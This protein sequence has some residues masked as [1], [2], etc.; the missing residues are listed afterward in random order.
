[1]RARVGALIGT[2][3]IGARPL[4]HVGLAI[5]GAIGV[6]LSAESD[7]PVDDLVVHLAGC[8]RVLIQVKR[9]VGL[10]QRAGQAV[11]RAVEQFARSVI[12]GLGPEDWLVLA[13]V[14]PVHALVQL[15]RLLD[16]ERLPYHGSPSGGE[17]RAREAFSRIARRYLDARGVKRLLARLVIWHT[18]PTQADGAAALEAHLETSVC[19]RGH[20][21]DAARELSDI[22]RSLARLRGGL[23]AVG[24][25]QAL[26]ARGVPLLADGGSD[27]PVAS[28]GALAAYRDRQQR[29]GSTL[30][31]F[32]APAEM[33]ELPLGEADAQIEVS[34]Q[35]AVHIDGE[36]LPG[37]ELPL[38]L[39]RRGRCLLVGLPG[40]GKST[41]L[42]ALCA[43]YARRPGWPLPVLVHLKR[44]VGSAAGIADTILDVAC[45]EVVGEERAILRTALAREFASGRCLLA[46]D[47]LDEVRRGRSALFAELSE[48]LSELPDGIEVI[49][50]TR[51][52]AAEDGHTLGLPELTLRPPSKP[53]ITIEAILGAA[54]PADE[55]DGAGWIETRRQW[56]LEAIRRDRSLGETP[57]TVVILALIAGRSQDPSRL[58]SDR[59]HLLRRALE[60]VIFRREIE[61]RHEGVVALGPLSDSSARVALLVA[62]RVLSKATL[63]E[64]ATTRQAAGAQLTVALK[65]QFTLRPGD[66]RAAAEDALE[67]WTDNGL[68]VFEGDQ[69]NARLR[70]LAEVAYAW[71]AAE[72]SNKA[73][74]RWLREA[75]A[76]HGLLAALTLGAGL[77]DRIAQRWAQEFAVNGDDYELHALSTASLDGV[78]FLPKGLAAIVERCASALMDTPQETER[79]V[80]SLLD[81]QLSDRLRARVRSL[82]ARKLSPKRQAVAEVLAITK[83]NERGPDADK[84]LRAFMRGD[85]P[86]DDDEGQS[87]E[88]AQAAAVRM[89]GGSREDAELALAHD[90]DNIGLLAIFET[91]GESELSDDLHAALKH[92][93]HNDLAD[94]V[95]A[96]VAAGRW[97]DTYWS[98]AADESIQRPLLEIVAALGDP[99]ALSHVQERR[100]DE[101]ADLVASAGV[102]WLP[103]RWP[104]ECLKTVSMWIQAV[105][106]LGGFNTSVLSSEARL[107]QA[108]LEAGES[109]V[110]LIHDDGQ[111]RQIKCWDRVEQVEPTLR[112]LVDFIGVF[113]MEYE[114]PFIAIAIAS[115]PDQRS[116]IALLEARLNRTKLRDRRLLA[117]TLLM[118]DG[119]AD[120]RASSWLEATDPML[121]AA[122]ATWWS[123]W[124]AG[125]A[126]IPNEFERCLLDPDES[127]RWWALS[128][129]R[130]ATLTPD[131]RQRL[132][133]LYRVE[134]RPWICEYCGQHNR[135]ARKPECEGCVYR[136]PDIFNRLSE[137]SQ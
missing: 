37:H 49:L 96:A 17:K 64:G 129:L 35:R 122:A 7:D 19:G 41:A 134:R 88:A 23:D 136:G 65:K 10:D 43:F 87:W 91:F 13:C 111:S 130:S 39:R 47:G 66:G 73:Q 60:D 33:A 127:V 84:Q 34:V 95:E 51:P 81:F 113:P 76:S 83:W 92:A 72:M 86:F 69:L 54:T 85:A 63:A 74:D 1:L 71:E 15:G 57:L 30:A 79:V 61:R 6:G 109:I 44:L 97:I 77:S 98:D 90:A 27:S 116:A 124:A 93:G 53:Q 26:Q 128:S 59:A 100:L 115:A 20:G 31:L 103:R 36:I 107:V 58:P 46:L 29:R 131:M 123:T 56:V 68:F 45:E 112:A 126:P 80:D 132:S 104:T 14:K 50:A 110:R 25:A 78:V 52:V 114:Q 67:F 55:K 70:P 106:T 82:L 118:V 28:A 101:L 24:L 3:V 121:R 48:W 62:L 16:R 94:K 38:A 135:P 117:N 99:I 75:R 12:E 21:D 11:D 105:A 2:A 42:R 137:L 22:V 8:G 133:A 18:D 89:A 40:G 5:P 32:G 4:E 9:S 119:A 125:S 120:R 108:E 102:A